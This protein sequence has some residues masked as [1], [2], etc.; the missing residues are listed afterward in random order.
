MPYVPRLKNDSSSSLA[1]WRTGQS[2]DTGTFVYLDSGDTS[3]SYLSGIFVCVVKHVSTSFDT[4]SVKWRSLTS[5][6]RHAQ[7]VASDTW[8][9]KHGLFRNPSVTI[10][11]SE[12]LQ[13]EGSVAHTNQS[14]LVIRF[15]SP[16]IGSAYCV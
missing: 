16:Q 14:N 13:I 10:L 9:V 1:K 4:D 2:Y 3:T 5:A 7:S 8:N 12:G 6:Y 15:N 11:N